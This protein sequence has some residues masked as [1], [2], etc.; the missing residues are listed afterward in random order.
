M[1]KLVQVLYDPRVGMLAFF[2]DGSVAEMKENPSGVR[3][4]IWKE[5]IVESAG[6]APA[7]PAFVEVVTREAPDFDAWREDA[8]Q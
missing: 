7:F 3:T 1:N 2:E 4:W 5:N 6:P 8:R